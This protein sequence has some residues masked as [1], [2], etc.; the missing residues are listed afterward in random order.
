MQLRTA[1]LLTTV[2]LGTSTLFACRS[3]TDDETTGTTT[4]SSSNGG[5]SSSSNMGGGTTGTGGGTVEGCEG[6]AATIQDI[7]TG[8]VGI[9]AK[10]SV[11]GVVAMSQKFLVS[12]SSTTNNCLWGVFV[13]APG[14]TE[15]AENTG[16]L[17]LSYGTKASIPEGQTKAFCPKLGQEP[18]G[19][20][21]PDGTLP[22]DVLDVVG[23]VSRF[24][25]PPMCTAPDPLNQV[26][27]LQLSGVCSA[28]KTGTAT[29]PTPHL[30][31]GADVTSLSSTTDKAFHDKW[32]AVKIRVEN[33]TVEPQA[34]MVV[35]DFGIIK[36]TNGVSVGDK[37]YYRGYSNNICHDG[38][39]FTD[40]AMTFN[41]I[42]G[43]H[44]LNYCTWDLEPND[45]CADFDPKS[46]DCAAATTCPPDT[47]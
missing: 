12:K 10:V 37:V 24:P 32:G 20:K 29:P 43:F 40:P 18:V 23:S 2:L 7:T 31:T 36:L 13:S 28:T 25:D 41:S 4:S 46:G 27:M 33:A 45:K 6:P 21:I 47:L 35:G 34:G 39:V 19:D 42:Q 15:T 3:G 22:G 8:T 38:P 9:G 17:I 16:L 1:Y 11:T 5:G 26:G 44:Y 14:I 30:M